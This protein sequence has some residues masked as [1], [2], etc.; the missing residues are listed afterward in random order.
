MPIPLFNLERVLN[1]GAAIKFLS[2]NTDIPLPKLYACFEDDNAAY[3]ITEYV[4]GVSMNEL[5]AEKQDII[6]QELRVH[7]ETLQKLKSNIWGGV[8][9]AVRRLLVTIEDVSLLI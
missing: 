7:M 4:E 9:G 6:A 8:G 3:I 2:D 5:D 1:E